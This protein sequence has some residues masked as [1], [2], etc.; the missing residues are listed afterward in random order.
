MSTLEGRSRL[1]DSWTLGLHQIPSP[2]Q[3]W[4][5]PEQEFDRGLQ[6]APAQKAQA[7][8]GSHRP[9]EI[10][11]IKLISIREKYCRGI[12]L[13]SLKVAGWSG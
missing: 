2:G 13:Q 11:Y 12:F 8:P 9:V 4:V 7:A 10:C 1:K 6:S 3:M 5:F